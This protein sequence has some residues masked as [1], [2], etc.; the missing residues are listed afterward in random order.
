VVRSDE[1]W[2]FMLAEVLLDEE[3]LIRRLCMSS[4]SH[5]CTNSA[6]NEQ[7]LGKDGLLL[8]SLSASIISSKSR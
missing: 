3:P 5:L 1:E 6:T 7:S 8:N 4:F 2:L